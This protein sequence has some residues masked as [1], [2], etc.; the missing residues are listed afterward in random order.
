MTPDLRTLCQMVFT[1]AQE[2][3]QGRFRAVSRE[4]KADGSIVTAA[5]RA[6]QARL[7]RDLRHHW[8][9]IPLLGEEMDT[10]TQEA[11]LH[12]HDEG[13]WCLDPVDGTTNFA[14]G[15]PIFAVSI[16]LIRNGAPVL[17]VIYDPI[18]DECFSAALG[19]GAWCNGIPLKPQTAPPLPDCIASIDLKRLSPTLAIYLMDHPPYGSQRN[20]GSSVLE[21]AWVATGRIH[22][23]LHGCQALW[24]YAAGVLILS[25]AGGQSMTLEG[26]PVFHADL[27]RRS[28]V[29]ALDRDA[30]TK[31]RAYLMNNSSEIYR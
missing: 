24:D 21:W 2:E 6:M 9:S 11:L 12:N 27:A 8:P 13:V 26:E 30:F 3:I 18:H 14:S 31:W 17:G 22:L 29:A 15:I 20:F 10:A 5:D 1:A 28:V 25:E 16:A 19:Q 4:F 7:E 23:Y